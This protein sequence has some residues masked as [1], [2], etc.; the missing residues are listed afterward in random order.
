[1]SRVADALERARSQSAATPVAP[2]SLEPAA[3]LCPR[4]PALASAVPGPDRPVAPA[5]AREQ[6]V[7]PVEGARRG[8]MALPPVYHRVRFREDVVE[9]V[10]I[11]NGAP[12]SAVEEFRKLA[13]TLHHAQGA[14]NLK[15]IM[16]T[17]PSGGEG[18]SLTTVN[19][20]LTLSGSYGRRVLLIDADLRKPALHEMFQVQNGAGLLTCLKTGSNE[21]APGIDVAPRLVLMPSGGLTPDPVSVLTSDAI[22]QL[23]R[24]A[25]QAFDWVLVDTP[26]A[27]MLPDCNLLAPA[28]DG[29][30]L[31]V[32]AFRTP[33]DI[34]QR[35]IEAVGREKVL[36]VVL[37]HAEQSSS[38]YGYGYAVS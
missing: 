24:D 28:V 38:P 18:K 16:V 11:E 10:A 3:S 19:L 25:S 17:S 27:A 26:P 37:N 13:A 34:A 22:I 1:M 31:I 35:A 30:L 8:W 20:A 21:I 14:H 33:Y 6:S 23:L 7:V 5:P 2:S 4:E 15:V 32:D 36:G 9:K 29:V 12:P